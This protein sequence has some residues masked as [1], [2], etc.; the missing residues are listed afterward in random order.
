MLLPGGMLILQ[1]ADDEQMT[2]AV[3]VDREPSS[4]GEPDET[5]SS[6]ASAPFVTT[7]TASKPITSMPVRSTRNS[8]LSSMS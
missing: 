1:V 7:S 8:W 6:T 3:N 5:F 4:S 2:G